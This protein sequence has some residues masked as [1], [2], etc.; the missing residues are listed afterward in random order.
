[1]AFAG[2]NRLVTL[3]PVPIWAKGFIFITRPNFSP[4]Y[5]ISFRLV[6]VPKS[7]AELTNPVIAGWG[8]FPI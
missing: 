2:P 6:L 1:L 8:C 5:K 4:Y 3:V 7:V